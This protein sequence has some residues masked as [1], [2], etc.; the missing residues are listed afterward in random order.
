MRRKAAVL[1]AAVLLLGMGAA[2]AEDDERFR[3]A[4]DQMMPTTKDPV[5]ILL[6]GFSVGCRPHFQDPKVD[7]SRIVID[8]QTIQS[9]VPCAPEA[10]SQKLSLPPLPAGGYTVEAFLGDTLLARQGFS[11]VEPAD[12]LSLH[13]GRL[14]VTATWK[15]PYSGKEEEGVGHAVKLTEESGAFWFFD[16][17]NQEVVVKI[18]DG[19]DVNAH[20]W[21]F[22]SSLTTVEYTVT[23]TEC[24]LNPQSFISCNSRTFHNEAFSNR[25]FVDTESF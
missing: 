15:N 25:N 13:G 17:N 16:S 22:I 6:S 24:P 3:L 14:T 2:R 5:V 19:R 10:W 11:V 8:G 12:A 18:L 20:W 23:V 1:F 9:L 7:G 21:I 4:L